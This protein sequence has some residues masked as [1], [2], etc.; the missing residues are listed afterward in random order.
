MTSQWSAADAMC[1]WSIKAYIHMMTSI[2]VAIMRF[3]SRIANAVHNANHI[4]LDRN[5]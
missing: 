1:L 3:Q 4:I 2:L 5:Q